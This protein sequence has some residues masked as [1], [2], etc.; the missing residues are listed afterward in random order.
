[1]TFAKRLFK[2]FLWDE[3]DGCVPASHPACQ[4]ETRLDFP[5]TYATH[6]LR[7]SHLRTDDKCFR[8][9]RTLGCLVPL[10][11]CMAQAARCRLCVWRSL[12]TSTSSFY[13][14]RGVA[15]AE[16]AQGTPIQT[17]ASPSILVYANNNVFVER[18][19]RQATPNAEHA[20]YHSTWVPHS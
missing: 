13:R 12:T 15:R 5:S 16:D 20:L 6:L 9:T 1:M 18:P 7:G 11:S 4:P 3:F 10:D 17:H 8:T 14:G 19:L 2:H